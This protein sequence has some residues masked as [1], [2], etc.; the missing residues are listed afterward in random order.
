[1]ER[2][3][4]AQLYRMVYQLNEKLGRP[5]TQYSGYG[6]TLTGNKGHLFLDHNAT[7]GGWQLSEMCGNGTG[8]RTHFSGRRFSA[9]EM[10]WMLYAVKETVFHGEFQKAA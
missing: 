7:Y 10:W 2:T 6:K 4:K 8:E 5:L 9:K 3:T 1:M